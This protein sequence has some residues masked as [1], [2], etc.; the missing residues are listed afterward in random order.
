MNKINDHLA[1]KLVLLFQ[2]CVTA[3]KS[4]L[5]R[6]WDWMNGTQIRTWKA[7]NSKNLMSTI[8]FIVT[9]IQATKLHLF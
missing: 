6:Q 3:S 7:G 1:L 2:F 5:L 9:Q 8:N 4:L